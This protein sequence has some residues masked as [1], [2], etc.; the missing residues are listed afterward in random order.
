LVVYEVLRVLYSPVKAFEEI[1]KKPSIKGPLLV[2]VLTLL[3]TAVLQSVVASKRFDLLPETPSNDNWT[4]SASLWTSNGV[5]SVDGT[6]RVV[7]NYSVKSFVANDTYIWM[8]ITDIGQFN[9]SGET[10]YEA[11]FFRIKWIHQNETFPSS[12]ATLRLFS[13]N[14]NGYFELNLINLINS[15][16]TWANV[17]VEVGSENPNWTSPNSPDWGNITGLE[18]KLAWSD[19]A[20]LTMKI[21]D[22]YFGKYV[23]WLTA[24]ASSVM[25]SSA[26]YAAVAFFFNWAIYGAFLLMFKVMF[27]RRTGS[28]TKFFVVIGHVFVV[29]AVYILVIA[30]LF[31]TLPQVTAETFQEKWVSNWV[32]Q[33]GYYLDFTFKAWMAVLF[34]IA[35]RFFSQLTWR[36]AAVVSTI[37]SIFSFFFT[38]PVL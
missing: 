26:L 21:D 10:G 6:D 2:L 12:N 28:L 35:I 8:N 18:F 7:G 3:A 17:T 36:K 32:F 27:R 23:S 19:A 13:N 33:F 34:A 38:L 15:S 9:C 29:T 20:N 31:L 16:D 1:V 4:E 25:I 22:L 37:A 14:E 24:V 11:L 5:P 30:L